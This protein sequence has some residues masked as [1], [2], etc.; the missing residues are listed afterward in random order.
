MIQSRHALTFSF[1]CTMRA[2]IIHLKSRRL[3]DVH[4]FVLNSNSLTKMILTYMY[5]ICYQ[6]N[7]RERG[8]ICVA[9]SNAMVLRM[10]HV[11]VCVLNS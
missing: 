8:E 10:F 5:Y 1:S 7:S 9:N 6:R 2:G 3:F 4:A 11:C